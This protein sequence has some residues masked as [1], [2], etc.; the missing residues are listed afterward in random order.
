V[1]AYTRIRTQAGDLASR[2]FQGEVLTLMLLAQGLLLALVLAFTPGFIR[3][4][5]PGFAA[6]GAAMGLAVELTRITFP[7]LALVSLVVLWTGVLNAEKRFAA[8]AAAPVLLNLAMISTLLLASFFA[9][10]AHAAAWGV[11]IA[12]VLEAGLL[13]IAAFRAGLLAPPVWPRWNGVGGSA[14]RDARR[15]NPCHVPAAGRSF[16]ALLCRSPLPIAHRG[17]RGGRRHGAAAGN[18]EAPRGR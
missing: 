5:A 7:Y 11:L 16:L 8:G 3:L 18:V 14:D 6:A 9:S 4:L 1:P 12:G 2:R 10:G 17:H 15:H 13:M